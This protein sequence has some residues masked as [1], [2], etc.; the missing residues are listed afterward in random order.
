MYKLKLLLISNTYTDNCETFQVNFLQK[1]QI[2][3]PSSSQAG[4]SAIL[5]IRSIAADPNLQRKGCWKT[6]V[7]LRFIT[8]MVSF[9][10][11]C[12]AT[13]RTLTANQ[14]N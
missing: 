1:Q 6:D 11:I 8:V 7:Q 12:T 4:T 3:F 2:H 14:Q 9:A 5:A 13:V 10:W